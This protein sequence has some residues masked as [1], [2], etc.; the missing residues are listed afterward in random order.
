MTEATNPRVNSAMWLGAF[1]FLAA[2]LSSLL[3]FAR[4]P[5]QQALPWINLAL[6]AAAVVFCIKALRRS[7]REPELSRGKP[8]G[9]TLSILAVILFLF[10]VM[11]FYVSRHLPS[12]AGAPQ[13]GQKAPDFTLRDTNGTPVTLAQLL[14]SPMPGTAE[15]PKAVLLIFYR[16]YW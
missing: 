2:F 9:W 12:P 7:Q 15:P 5:G 3:F 11:G 14:S 10:S 4:V 1:L 13:V 16:G 6:G 8:A